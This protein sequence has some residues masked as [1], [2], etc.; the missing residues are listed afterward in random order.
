MKHT[1]Y[2]K[3]AWEFF[4]MVSVQQVLQSPHA[5]YILVA[6]VTVAL[7][8][9]SLRCYQE[10]IQKDMQQIQKQLEEVFKSIQD[11]HHSLV[12]DHNEPIPAESLNRLDITLEMAIGDLQTI[13][14]EINA[15][16][17]NE[18]PNNSSKII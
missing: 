4:Q 10:C 11:V 18:V 14:N 16:R 2:F 7:C 1:Q 12:E 8:F 17:N 3:S 5:L 13:E 15:Q 6:L 9:A